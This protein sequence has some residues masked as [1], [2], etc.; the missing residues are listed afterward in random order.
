[1]TELNGGTYYANVL[2]ANTFSLYSDTALTTPVDTSAFTDYS[3]PGLDLGSHTLSLGSGV[4]YHLGISSTNPPPIISVY[5]PKV[6][7]KT[8]A[9]NLSNAIDAVTVFANGV[10]SIQP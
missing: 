10:H 3:Y 7:T 1:M 4:A 9:L 6:T 2:T 5:L 8:T